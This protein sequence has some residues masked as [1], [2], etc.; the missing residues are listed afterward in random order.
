MAARGAQGFQFLPV[1][2]MSSAMKAKVTPPKKGAGVG[3]GQLQ[4]PRAKV[5]RKAS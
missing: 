5:K 3:N 4:S 2:M 1:G